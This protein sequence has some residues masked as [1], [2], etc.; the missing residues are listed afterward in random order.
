MDNQ[1]GQTRKLQVNTLASVL[2][3]L[4]KLSSRDVR[5]QSEDSPG[6]L[7]EPSEGLYPDTL[8]TKSDSAVRPQGQKRNLALVSEGE[9]GDSPESAVMDSSAF[10]QQAWNE[11]NSHSAVRASSDEM[12]RTA[13]GGP[14]LPLRDDSHYVKNGYTFAT[15]VAALTGANALT[16]HPPVGD[17]LVS[18]V[19]VGVQRHA[20]VMFS[21]PWEPLFEDVRVTQVFC[22]AVSI[23]YD[24]NPRSARRPLARLAL[25]AV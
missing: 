21:S 2:R 6:E 15:S 14:H 3:A 19:Q 25:D 20:G 5:R 10:T 22:S 8:L 18:R 17:D 4:R 23:P 16:A 12:P 11:E 9:R 13:F 24:R 7:I 1:D